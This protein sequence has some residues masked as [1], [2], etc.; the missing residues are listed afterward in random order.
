[1]SGKDYLKNF[2]EYL[3]SGD[4]DSGL[5]EAVEYLQELISD[6]ECLHLRLQFLQALSIK[7]DSPDRDAKRIKSGLSNEQYKACVRKGFVGA[8]SDSDVSFDQLMKLAHDVDG[9]RTFMDTLTEV[10]QSE[11]AECW[12]DL[13]NANLDIE[14][15]DIKSIVEKSATSEIMKELDSLIKRWIDSLDMKPLT[16]SPGFRSAEPITIDDEVTMKDKITLRAKLIGTIDKLAAIDDFPGLAVLKLP[17]DELKMHA[18]N[19]VTWIEFLDAGSQTL[20]DALGD[21]EMDHLT[22]WA[23]D[24]SM[25][26]QSRGEYLLLKML[27]LTASISE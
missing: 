20:Q 25:S 26:G 18:M 24:E 2:T 16:A 9:L 23:F 4:D 21:A 11:H 22:D 19:E 6:P 10:P 12:K 15:I 1:M 13:L 14:P 7:N 17:T 8:Y 5:K 27:I 3:N